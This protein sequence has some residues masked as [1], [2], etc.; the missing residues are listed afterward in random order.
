MFSMVN[1]KT[2]EVKHRV[3]RLMVNVTCFQKE[4]SPAGCRAE[5]VLAGGFAWGIPGCLTV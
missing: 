1:S 2:P 5:L 4:A 3:R